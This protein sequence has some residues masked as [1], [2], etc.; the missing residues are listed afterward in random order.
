MRGFITYCSKYKISTCDKGGIIN[1]FKRIEL[2]NI[3]C[4]K[5]YAAFVGEGSKL[6]LLTIQHA[7]IHSR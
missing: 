2:L 7:K 4:W 3:L 1:N 5:N 6:S